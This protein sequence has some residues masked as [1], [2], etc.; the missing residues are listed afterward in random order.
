MRTKT[1]RISW[2]WPSRRLPCVIFFGVF[3]CFACKGLGQDFS[4][5]RVHYPV[6]PLEAGIEPN[7]TVFGATV[8]STNVL[9]VGSYARLDRIGRQGF[10]YDHFGSIDPFQ[11][12]KFW[13][14]EELVGTVPPS[15][16]PSAFVISSFQSVNSSGRVVGLIRDSVSGNDL[17]FYV[18][19]FDVQPEMLPIPIPAGASGAQG[20]AVNETG[21]ILVAYDDATGADRV[22]VYVPETG[23]QIHVPMA[24]VSVNRG[25][26]TT[27]QFLGVRADGVFVRYTITSND[28][29]GIVE[30]FPYYYAPS[31]NGSDS[32][33]NEYGEFAAVIDVPTGRGNKTKRYVA[34][35]GGLPGAAV[36]QW[37]F[38]ADLIWG[39]PEPKTGQINNAGDILVRESPNYSGDALLERGGS[40]DEFLSI[41]GLVL[42]ASDPDR[43]FRDTPINWANAELSDRDAS[44]QGWL[45]GRIDYDNDPNGGNGLFVLIPQPA[46]PGITV[47][48]P[49]GIVTTEGGGTGSFTIVLNSEPIANVSIGISSSDTTEGTVNVASLTFTPVNWDIPQ[50]VTINGVDDLIEDGDVDY[51][52]I[53]DAATST[54]PDYNGLNPDDVQ[55]TNLDNDGP[56]EFF[57]TDTPIAIPDYNPANPQGINSTISVPDDVTITGLTVTLNITHQ[58]P[59]DLVVWLYGPDN[60]PP[61]QLS[62]LSGVNNVPDFN[63][64]SSL[65]DWTLEVYDTVKKKTGTLNGWSITIEH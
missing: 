63:G 65:G 53:I 15:W 59:A 42:D 5:Y 25:F 55:V 16:A 29:S 13:D 17:P 7:V 22:C 51:T 57:S 2:W 43:A 52:I 31:I 46:G 1:T 8:G 20:R 12:E 28:G 9:F 62:N 38:E 41:K 24:F 11:P 35:Y 10:I 23:Q 34:R 60:G 21:E 45:A 6:I 40:P 27:R 54:D 33:I 30:D 58:R 26:N 37:R 18:D 61:V 56:L 64:T 19:V 50:T 3:A 14:V 39:G 47:T 49:N 44:G 48:P 32:R 4:G 36:E